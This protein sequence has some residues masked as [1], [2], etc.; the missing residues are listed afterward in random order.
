MSGRKRN[1]VTKRNVENLID[2]KAKTKKQ[3]HSTCV[4]SSSVFY[5]GAGLSVVISLALFIYLMHREENEFE[6]LVPAASKVKRSFYKVP[7]SNDYKLEKFEACKPKTC[8]RVV[9]DDLIDE[10]DALH[11]LSVAKKGLALGG[12]SGGASI[13][14]LH[15]G[16]L[17]KDNAFINIYNVIKSED[18]DLLSLQDFSIYRKVKNQIHYAIARQ[19]NIPQDKLYLTKP[20]FFSRMNMKEPST[21]HDEYWHA[22]VDKETYGSFHYTSLLYLSTYEQDFT[23]GRFIFIDKNSNKTVEPRLGRVSFFTSGSENLHRVERLKDGVRY[24]ITV[25]FTCDPSQAIQDPSYK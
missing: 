22:H 15:S 24:A 9:M 5:L 16:A 7:C 17:S 23:G 1:T 4:V 12:S 8:G 18:I 6:T 13:L 19:F 21:I 14:D 2:D 11:L 10:D 3:K 25:S 20:T